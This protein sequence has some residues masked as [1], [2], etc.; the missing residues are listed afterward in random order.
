MKYERKEIWWM[1]CLDV[2]MALLAWLPIFLREGS[3]QRIGEL[4]SGGYFFGMSIL[5]DAIGTV[6]AILIARFPK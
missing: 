1:F 3:W 2:V 6:G 5:M 4:T